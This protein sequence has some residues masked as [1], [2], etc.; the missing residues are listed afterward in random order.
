MRLFDR[1]PGIDAATFA[2]AQAL[3]DDGLDLAF[4]LELYPDDAGWLAP[5][6]RTGATVSEA[7]RAEQSSYYFEATLKAKFLAAAAAQQAAIPATEPVFD[8]PAPGP[9]A[10]VRALAAGA[11]VLGASA[12]MAVLTLGLVTADKSVPGD[13]NYVFKRTNERLEYSLS[14]GDSRI[15][16]QLKQV[17]ARIVE[18]QQQLRDS[19]TV[20]P[21]DVERLQ[22]EAADLA[23]VAGKSQLDTTQRA[24]LQE[25]GEKSVAVL[26][27]VGQKQ[28]D[29]Q[30]VVEQA[31]ST[32]NSAVA[33]G[34]GGGVGTVDVPTATPTAT[35]PTP[36]TSTPTAT[37]TDE[38]DTQSTSTPPP[39]PTSTPTATP[40]PPPSETPSTPSVTATV[41]PQASA[42]P[43]PAESPSATPQ[44]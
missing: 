23:A 29:L 38:S 42:T 7:A 25:F 37:P 34:L 8:A 43:S 1:A 24:R 33:A 12:V 30:P 21:S 10:R 40:T 27:N 39:T 35:T 9:F 44:P 14:R 17:D 5:L 3:V 28:T 32:V 11:A 41:E 31:I 19:G 6:L 4:V 13:W 26:N 2:E 15:D 20:S 36:D 22:R 16:V 18:I